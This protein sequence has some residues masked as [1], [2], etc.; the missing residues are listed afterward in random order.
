MF[1]NE[2]LLEFNEYLKDRKV[3]IIGLGVS[4]IPLIDYLRERRANVTVFD[5]RT[6][7]KLDKTIMDRVVD[8]GMEFSIGN[9]YLSKLKG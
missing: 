7:D 6:I 1:V 3:A 4:N 5:K 2:K 9:N 8:Y